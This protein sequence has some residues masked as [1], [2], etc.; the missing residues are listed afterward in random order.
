VPRGAAGHAAVAALASCARG[1]T[2]REEER[3]RVTR[4][5]R[6]GERQGE[7]ARRRSVQQA[8]ARGACGRA[9]HAGQAGQATAALGWAS[10]LRTLGRGTRVGRTRGCWAEEGAA[11][12]WDSWAGEAT[13][14]RWAAWLGAPSGPWGQAGQGRWEGFPFYFIFLSS[15]S[16]FVENML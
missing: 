8:S 16:S 7:D 12:L 2:Q 1:P 15:F 11:W 4:A 9:W 5:S 6:P 14:A 10:A 13:C 3:G